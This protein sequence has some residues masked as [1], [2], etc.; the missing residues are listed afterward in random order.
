M[1]RLTNAIVDSE[2]YRREVKESNTEVFQREQKQR[3]EMRRE[4]R[5]V[6]QFLDAGRSDALR[7]QVS[8]MAGKSEETIRAM[9]TRMIKLA[10]SPHSLTG[11]WDSHGRI[12]SNQE[13][14][15]HERTKRSS[16]RDK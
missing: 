5:L 13:S 8:W 6:L 3:D 11:F 4:A 12:V 14:A 15:Q 7:T 1:I 16:W 2:S 10:D 9:A